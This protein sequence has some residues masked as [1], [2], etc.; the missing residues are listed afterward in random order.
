MS[1]LL[2]YNIDNCDPEEALVLLHWL[3]ALGEA[4]NNVVRL[5]TERRQW[6]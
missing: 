1:Q 6:W 4:L 5:F 3:D 2:L